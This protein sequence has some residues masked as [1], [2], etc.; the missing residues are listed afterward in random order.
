MRTTTA[1][2]RSTSSYISGRASQLASL[3]LTF[4]MS[5]L[6]TLTIQ[7]FCKEHSQYKDIFARTALAFPLTK[8]RTHTP[9]PLSVQPSG[10]IVAFFGG[11]S[12]G[13]RALTTLSGC[14]RALLNCC[15][16]AIAKLFDVTGGNSPQVRC[17]TP[18]RSLAMM[19]I[20]SLSTTDVHDD[21]SPTGDDSACC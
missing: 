9:T 4:G 5:G 21:S 20:S 15:S 2:Y 6:G 3:W 1:I 7:G 14:S 12:V 8:L 17:W 16:R 19:L 10:T 18:G 13:N 11:L